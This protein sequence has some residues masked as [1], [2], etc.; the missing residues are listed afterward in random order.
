MRFA[1]HQILQQKSMACHHLIRRDLLCNFDN[2]QLVLLHQIC[3]GHAVNHK[4]RVYTAVSCVLEI[5][6][7]IRCN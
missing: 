2:L 5:S 1:W 4:L 7:C 6:H 3:D